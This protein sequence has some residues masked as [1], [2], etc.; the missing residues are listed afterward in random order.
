MADKNNTRRTRLL[1]YSEVGE[2]LGYTENTVRKK[3]SAGE[4]PF[5]KVK[6]TERA[7]RFREA[8]VE[9]WIEGHSGNGEAS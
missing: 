7:V 4:L 9:A 5:E 8:D 3:V 1:T 6:L 2:M